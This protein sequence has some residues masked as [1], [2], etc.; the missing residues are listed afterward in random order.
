MSRISLSHLLIL[1]SGLAFI[2]CNRGC[3]TQHTIKSESKTISTKGGN[4]E[5]VGRVIDYRHSRRVG[6]NIFERSVSHTYGLCFDLNFGTF[7]EKM[8][9]TEGV[10]NPDNVDLGVELE[11][12]KVAISDDQNHIGLGVDGKVVEIIHLYKS[13]RI[14]TEKQDLNAD[15]TMDWSKL[16]INSYPSVQSILK[17]SLENSCDKMRGTEAIYEYCNASKPS[18]K[19]HE[20]MLKK[21]PECS[22]A[23]N[24]LTERKIRELSR[25]KK[26]KKRAEKRAGKI[27]NGI[28]RRG[29][30]IREVK[31]MIDAL[32]SKKL[33]DRYDELIVKN[34]G[35]KSVIDY[36][37]L[38][39]ER[40][41]EKGEPM[42]KNFRRELH[43]LAHDEF[44][45]FQQTG[46]SNH[47]REAINCLEVLN[48]MGDTT[49]GYNFVQDAFGANFQK[50]NEFDFL[51]VAYENISVYTPY[52]QRLIIEKTEGMF[53]KVGN[54]TRSSYYG[55]IEDLVDCSMLKR[56]KNAYPEDLKFKSV[57]MRCG[58]L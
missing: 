9:F 4:A 58:K 36:T 49:A 26:W 17:E 21:W 44:S 37:E 51:E 23:K 20:I 16:D 2:G 42:D 18:A 40:L 32:D 6:D 3:T 8:F 13:N 52:Q 25:D 14:Y 43:A 34:W 1:F 53:E 54:S 50:Y 56:L 27:L 15:G 22:V 30:N 45:K 57:P 28:E 47:E 41:T 46:K 31:L 35:K 5:V 55:A 19:I 24:Y 10:D 11:R 33:R 7:Q 39:V 38:V 29:F 48:A 12:V